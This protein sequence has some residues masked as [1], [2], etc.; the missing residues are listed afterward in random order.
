MDVFPL[1]QHLQ[2]FLLK[3]RLDL[4][5]EH[6][7][8]RRQFQNG[9]DLVFADVNIADDALADQSG[10]GCGDWTVILNVRHDP[11]PVPAEQ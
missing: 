8:H 6:C 4:V 10:A 9:I 5:G 1:L 2:R 11:N 3:L 7:Q